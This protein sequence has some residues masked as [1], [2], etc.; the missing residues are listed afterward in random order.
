M[1]VDPPVS[2]QEAL[3]RAMLETSNLRRRLAAA[4]AGEVL[5]AFD[6]VEE[7]WGKQDEEQFPFSILMKDICDIKATVREAFGGELELPVDW[8]SPVYDQVVEFDQ[9]IRIC[10]GLMMVNPVYSG[11]EKRLQRIEEVLPPRSYAFRD[12][13][14]DLRPSF[15]LNLKQ[16]LEAALR[17]FGSAQY[18]LTITECGK[19]EGILFPAFKKIL[20]RRY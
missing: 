7:I 10:S 8:R 14:D 1:S 15:D 12:L 20:L 6:R 18:E 17:Y 2:S 11:L 9:K 4:R 5:D 16:R 13:L 3:H 19:A